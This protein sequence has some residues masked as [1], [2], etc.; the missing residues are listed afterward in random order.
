MVRVGQG[1]TLK[2]NAAPEFPS[3]S[4]AT[5]EV[6]ENSPAG[7][8]VGAPVTAS[9]SDGDTLSYS[10]S[11]T[12]AFTIDAT[13]SQIAVASNTDLDHEA[14]SSYTVTVT[15]SDGLDTFGDP[16][17]SAD[18]SITVTITVT[19]VDEAAGQARTRRQLTVDPPTLLRAA[20]S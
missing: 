20:W 13:T 16:D 6:A 3:G 17:P 14:V 4:T 15:V 19:D 8:L 9:D 18:D 2:D 10:L 11:G 7:T 12:S 5:R 1:A